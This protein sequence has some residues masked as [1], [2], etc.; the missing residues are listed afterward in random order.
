ML[1]SSA[2]HSINQWLEEIAIS[3]LRN[4]VDENRAMKGYKDIRKR[5]ELNFSGKS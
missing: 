3:V 5:K 2:I 4:S 1:S